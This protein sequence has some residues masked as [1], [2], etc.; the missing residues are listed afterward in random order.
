MIS[1]CRVLVSGRVRAEP[2]ESNGP[3]RVRAEPKESNGPSRVGLYSSKLS[4]AESGSNE[5]MNG[6]GRVLS[7]LPLISRPKPTMILYMNGK[8]NKKNKKNKI[9][10]KKI[11]RKGKK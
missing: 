5:R 6:P 4:R 1:S 7:E 9:Q 2:K 11:L 10:R 3:S 8:V